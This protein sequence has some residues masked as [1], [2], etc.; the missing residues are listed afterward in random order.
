MVVRT[1]FL[2]ALA[3]AGTFAVAC[4]ASTDTT[5]KPLPTCDAT[6]PSC[7]GINSPTKKA[8]TDVPTDPV[9]VPDPTPMTDAA[10][11]EAGKDAAP[12]VGMEC[13]GLATCCAQLGDAGFVT[14]TCLDVLSTNNENACY[15]Q[16]AVYKNS[17]DCT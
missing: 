12:V 16:H 11:M 8:P 3:A 6:D 4:T 15:T 17:G 13:K 10:P 2:L 9:V 7:P 5:K 1:A 14:T